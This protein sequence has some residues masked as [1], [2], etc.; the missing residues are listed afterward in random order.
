MNSVAALW[1]P[2]L[3]APLAVPYCDPCAGPRIPLGGVGPTHGRSAVGTLLLECVL[4]GATGP[5]HVLGDDLGPLAAE[6]FDHLARHHPGTAV[7]AALVM[8]QHSATG[9]GTPAQV[10]AWAQGRRS[11]AEVPLTD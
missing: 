10:A 4:C 5:L 9:I 8:H 2:D 7:S 3:P 1:G 6:A 11:S